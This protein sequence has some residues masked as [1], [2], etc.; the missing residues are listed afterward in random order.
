MLL[1]NISHFHR[2]LDE[3]SISQIIGSLNDNMPAI[4]DAT[5]KASI[6]LFPMMSIKQ[7]QETTRGYL[8]LCSDEQPSIR[9]NSLICLG[10]VDSK[11]IPRESFVKTLS[12]ISLKDAFTSARK[13]ALATV[14]I[15]QTVFTPEDIFKF[16]IPAISPLIMDKTD[17]DIPTQAVGLLKFF[18]KNN[19]SLEAPAQIIVNL[20]ERIEPSERKP[21][22]SI[23]LKEPEIISAD[24]KNTLEKSESQIKSTGESDS[25]S[26]STG[27]KLRLGATKTLN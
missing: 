10:K 22:T 15:H 12:A 13:M 27:R 25:S 21:S 14:K 19:T 4:R 7:S 6:S 1:D 26:A 20:P 23:A 16:L 17:A 5:L 24:I 18:V 11:N 2:F 9:T 8:K 3:K